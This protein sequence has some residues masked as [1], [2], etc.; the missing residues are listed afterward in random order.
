[1]SEATVI[2]RPIRDLLGERDFLAV[3]SVGALSGIVRWFQLLAFGLYTFE[4]TG[5]PLLVASIPVLWMLPLTLFGPVVGV[6]S[7]YLD[8]KL[9]LM[10]ATALI[11]ALQVVMGV[12]AHAGELNYLMLALTSFLSGVFWATDMPLRRRVLGDLSRDRISAA[13]G[14]DS[15]TGNATRMAGPLFGGVVLQF[16]GM[17]GVFVMSAAIF[18]AC[19]LLLAI[20]RVPGTSIV[21]VRHSLIRNLAGGARLVMANRQ[22]RRI[23]AVT[24]VFNLWGFPFTSMIP[25]IGRDTLDLTPFLVGVLSSMEGLGALVGALLVAA[26]ARPDYFFRIY[27][28]GTV[29][30][31][32]TIGYLGLLTFIAGGPYHSFVASG[33]ALWVAGLASACFAAMQGTLTYLAA[34]PAYRSRVL[35]VLTL[36]IG[37]GPLGF[38][39]VGWMAESFGVATALLITSAEGLVA[40]LILW[41]W[42]APLPQPRS[43]EPA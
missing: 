3:W 37:T 42:S 33:M 36:C 43:G 41:A 32:F 9:M 20:A 18:W 31:L 14:L 22:L 1:M 4:I 21:A 19:V 24:I 2:E 30:Y 12:L 6:L 38:L 25:V 13:M 34:P 40:L 10:V 15:A 5:S 39:N 7:E 23:F 27:L 8:R 35:G 28:S 16:L 11:A 26:L 17:F 29:L